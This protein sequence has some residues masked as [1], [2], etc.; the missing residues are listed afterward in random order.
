MNERGWNAQK[1]EPQVQLKPSVEDFWNISLKRD[2][3]VQ[4]SRIHLMKQNPSAR[5]IKLS[6]NLQRRLSLRYLC[7]SNS[8]PGAENNDHQRNL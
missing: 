8:L 6:M 5:L 7:D 1:Q 4:P 3:Q 2:W